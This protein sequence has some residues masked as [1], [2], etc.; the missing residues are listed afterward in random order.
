MKR[1]FSFVLIFFTS[2]IFAQEIPLHRTKAYSYALNKNSLIYDKETQS[3][4]NFQELNE[5]LKKYPNADLEV[6]EEDINGYALSYYFIQEPNKKNL[7]I[8]PIHVEIN[9]KD[10][11]GNSFNLEII[12]SKYTLII[13]QQDLEF[14]R[15]NIEDIKE[16]EFAA[17]KRGYTS[18]ILSESNLNQAK[19]FS[20]E[21]GLNSVIIPNARNLINRFNSKR[22][23]LYIILN[24]KKYIISS[25]KYSYEVEDEL[26]VL[27]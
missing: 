14:P 25:L 1:I 10:V 5:L 22:F 6:K 13:L 3:K 26:L 24:A 4:I 20:K 19:I 11:K 16:A 23:P 7:D 12:N 15:I 9:R 2:L 27:D 21:Q 17:I 8:K 18:V